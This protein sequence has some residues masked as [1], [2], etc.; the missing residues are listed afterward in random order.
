[1][2]LSANVADKALLLQF[3]DTAKVI[4]NNAIFSC[5]FFYKIVYYVVFINIYEMYSIF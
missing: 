1:M 4:T 5:V 3:N 2:A